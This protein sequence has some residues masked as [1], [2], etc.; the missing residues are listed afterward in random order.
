MEN[1]QELYLTYFAAFSI[2][3]GKTLPFVI[4]AVN[5]WLNLQTKRVKSI[6]SWVVP[7][8]VMYA[9]WGLGHFFEGSFLVGLEAWHPLAY[10]AWAALLSNMEWNNVPWLKEAVN[11]FF[12]WLL[13]K[14]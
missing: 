5:R 3:V 14:K 13:T 12:T 11:S 2:V 6:V 7:V 9:G 4:E 8:L 1:L 10:G